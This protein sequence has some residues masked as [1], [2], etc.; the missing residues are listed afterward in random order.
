MD[1]STLSPE[2]Q[3]A[4]SV[5]QGLTGPAQPGS[6]AVASPISTILPASQLQALSIPDVSKFVSDAFEKLK[7]YYQKL[8]TEAQ[9]DTNLAIKNLE[10]DY[11]TGIRN[12]Q[13]NLKVQTGQQTDNLQAALKSLG[14]QTQ[15]ETDTL[16]DSLNKRGVLTTE[17][18]VTG[19]LDVGTQGV[20]GYQMGQLRAD[21][22]LRKE[23]EQRTTAQNLTNLGITA[24]QDTEK[25]ATNQT[26]GTQTALQNYR[27]TAENYQQQAEQQAV[28]LGTTKEQQDNQ[29]KLQSQLAATNQAQ[30]GG[31]TGGSSGLSDSQK[32]INPQSKVWDD[33]YYATTGRFL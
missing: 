4:M 31:G 10:D 32:H 24:K 23:A 7:P 21:Q 30:F 15:G 14:I 3:Q 2:V 26:R 18:P 17:N 5:I 33:N 28:Q 13:E 16:M 19:K 20:G 1:L 22:D 6:N 12:T 29:A 9:G 8:L 11:Q 25:L 27:N